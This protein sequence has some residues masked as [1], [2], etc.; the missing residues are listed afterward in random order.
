MKKDVRCKDGFAGIFDAGLEREEVPAIVSFVC[1][2][3]LVISSRQVLKAQIENDQVFRDDLTGQLL[4]PALVRAAR[5]KELEYLDEKDVWEL[6]PISECRRLMGKA[7]V[8]VRGVDVNRGRHESQRPVALNREADTPG[9][10]GSH[11]RADT[12]A[13]RIEEYHLHGGH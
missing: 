8:T 11:L 2:F 13:R 9:G 1:C 5:K 3:N 6:R 12:T 4:D 10:R 7:P